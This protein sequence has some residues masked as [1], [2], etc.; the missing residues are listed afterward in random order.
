MAGDD[1]LLR[2]LAKLSAEAALVEERVASLMRY[3]IHTGKRGP[4]QTSQEKWEDEVR[5]LHDEFGGAAI[6]RPRARAAT[7]E[8]PRHARPA[9]PQGVLTCA[10]RPEFYLVSPT[11]V[12]TPVADLCSAWTQQPWLPVF[13]DWKVE[14][15]GSRGG[16]ARLLFGR[17]LLANQPHRRLQKRRES[18]LAKHRDFAGPLIARYAEA[19]KQAEGWD[20]TGQSLS[21]I[22]QQ[23]LGRDDGL[24]R[25]LPRG[26][27]A[28]L[29]GASLGPPVVD[30][31]APPDLDRQGTVALQSLWVVDRFGQA[32]VL[33]IAEESRPEELEFFTNEPAAKRKVVLGRRFLEPTR[34]VLRFAIPAD[35]HSPVLGWVVAHAKEDSLVFYTAKG[36]PRGVLFMDAAGAAK[37]RRAPEPKPKN[38]QKSVADQTLDELIGSLLPPA[39]GKRAAAFMRTAKQALARPRPKAPPAGS[40]TASL[41]GRPLLLVRAEL[42]LERRG[43]AILDPRWFTDAAKLGALAHKLDEE[44]DNARASRQSL[45]VELGCPR[46]DNGVIGCWQDLAQPDQQTLKLALRLP[47]SGQPVPVPLMMLID[48]L[49]KIYLESEAD[50]LPIQTAALEAEWFEE[51]LRKLPAVLRIG[52]VLFDSPDTL[53]QAL[54]PHAAAARLDLPLPTAVGQAEPQTN[55]DARGHAVLSLLQGDTLTELALEPGRPLPPLSDREVAAAEGLLIL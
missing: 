8:Q 55:G 9:P 7:D 24:P 50:C 12:E 52:P 15:T 1:E 48:P 53:E 46:P 25:L 40:S 5:R 49:G 22:Y 2:I 6:P 51:E 13:L 39:G 16:A 41:C 3:E 18:F 54:S 21:G 31:G 37:W 35:A 17:T 42:G 33:S 34:L 29:K 26:D 36:T 14:W 10:Q 30:Q 44:V 27:D 47:L 38:P 4:Q 43:G 19:L 45:S 11:K 23:L 28:L 32:L 20:L